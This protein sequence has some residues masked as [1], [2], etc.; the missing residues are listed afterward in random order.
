MSLFRGNAKRLLELYLE[1]IKKFEI[2]HH[3]DQQLW[4]LIRL[5]KI[6]FESGNWEVA[7]QLAQSRLLLTQNIENFEMEAV[8]HADLIT[9]YRKMANTVRDK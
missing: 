1:I 4:A 8:A 2:K 6:E 3:E 7:I 9:I 5:G